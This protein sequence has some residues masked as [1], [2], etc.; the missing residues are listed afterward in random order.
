MDF[1]TQDLKVG[2]QDLK[3]GIQDLKVG[4]QDLKVGMLHL[5]GTGNFPISFPYHSHTSRDSDM[6]VGLGWHGGPIYFYF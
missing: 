5:S 2:I 6:G 3:V 1:G 4:I